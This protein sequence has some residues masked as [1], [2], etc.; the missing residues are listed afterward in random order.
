MERLIPN[1]APAQ[2]TA[3][4]L[5]MIR[6]VEYAIGRICKHLI[7]VLQEAGCIAKFRIGEGVYIPKNLA[8]YKEW[9]NIAERLVDTDPHVG[10]GILL[11]VSPK[12][13]PMK[14]INL[15]AFIRNEE[16]D[17]KNYP[18]WHLVRE[19]KELPEEERLSTELKLL[20]QHKV[21]F[22]VLITNKTWQKLVKKPIF[23]MRGYWELEEEMWGLYH[24]NESKIKDRMIPLV[25]AH[26]PF[27]PLRKIKP[28]L[29]KIFNQKWK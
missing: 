19:T 23:W 27:T 20:E 24:R 2:P 16:K 11:K 25:K 12:D 6:S 14:Q 26:E 1:T 9:S 18:R 13:D 15:M 28:A 8:N 17:L 10:S 3:A 22:I 29:D 7:P 21:Y 5:G 4:R